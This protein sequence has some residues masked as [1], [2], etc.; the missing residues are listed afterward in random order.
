MLFVCFIIGKKIE[1]NHC[2]LKRSRNSVLSELKKKIIISVP[3]LT[4]IYFV[5]F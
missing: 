5:I 2:V 1:Y 4:I 3:F